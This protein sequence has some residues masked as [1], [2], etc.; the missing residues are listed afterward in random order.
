MNI[1]ALS[2]RALNIFHFVFNKVLLRSQ[3]VTFRRYVPDAV[4][5][6]CSNEERRVDKKRVF[7]PLHKKK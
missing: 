5:V 2:E 4:T 7:I 3:R 6:L 1:R